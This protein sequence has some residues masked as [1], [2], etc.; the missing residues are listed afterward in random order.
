MKTGY[1]RIIALNI[2]CPSCI[3]CLEGIGKGCEL[4][5][6]TLPKERKVQCLKC[7]EW[8]ILPPVA[9]RM[10]KQTIEEGALAKAITKRLRPE[11]FVPYGEG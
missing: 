4:D 6:E 9:R 7:H 1:Y 8:Y 3:T 10:A 11:A 5:Y 2:S